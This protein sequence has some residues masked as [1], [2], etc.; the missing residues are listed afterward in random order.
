MCLLLF[1]IFLLFDL[2]YTLHKN[3]QGISMG[4]FILLVLASSFIIPT[5]IASKV[6][7]GNHYVSVQSDGTIN[8]LEANLTLQSSSSS[9]SSTTYSIYDDTNNPINNITDTNS[10][11]TK[12]GARITAAETELV[13]TN[14]TNA[15]T[16]T[17][18]S[19]NDINTLKEIFFK[20]DIKRILR[21]LRNESL[22]NNNNND[23]LMMM[24][25]ELSLMVKNINDKVK[26]N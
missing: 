13:L 18:N 8:G 15:N 22:D 24:V 3:S 12:N 17:T 2:A 21:V 9:S 25:L 5:I 10:C 6:K 14:T 1:V 23:D 19:N 20:D 11:I 7:F 4:T 16:N 26:T